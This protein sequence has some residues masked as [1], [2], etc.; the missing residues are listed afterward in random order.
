MGSDGNF[1][2]APTLLSSRNPNRALSMLP[3]R[4]RDLGAA[5]SD[6]SAAAGR[7]G[8]LGFDHL[9]GDDP[10]LLSGSGLPVIVNVDLSEMA[11]DDPFVTAHPEWVAVRLDRDTMSVVDP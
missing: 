2:A 4:I 8:A 10:L 6:V 7:L 5:R 9:A 11:S 1:A 3:P